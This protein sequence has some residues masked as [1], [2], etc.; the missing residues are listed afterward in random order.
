VFNADDTRYFISLKDV[1]SR[2]ELSCTP[3]LTSVRRNQLSGLSIPQHILKDIMCFPAESKHFVELSA[4]KNFLS[5]PLCCLGLVS[6]LSSSHKMSLGEDKVRGKQSE[7]R[8]R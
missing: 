7:N 1:V 6:N 5:T 2:P 3:H 8:G 4:A